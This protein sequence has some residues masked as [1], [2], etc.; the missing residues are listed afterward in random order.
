MYCKKTYAQ[1]VSFSGLTNFGRE[2]RGSVTGGGKLFL[3]ATASSLVM[4]AWDE[5]A[6]VKWS[7]EV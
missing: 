2:D 1:L 6:E 7:V 5:D 4:L 3:F